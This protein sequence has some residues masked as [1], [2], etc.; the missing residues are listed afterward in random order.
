MSDSTEHGQVSDDTLAA[1]EED[2][3]RHTDAGSP[4]TPEEEAAADRYKDAGEGVEAPYR[5]MT[6][7]GANAKGEGRID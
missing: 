7:K 1:E 3:Q 6:E 5:D 2:E 4:P